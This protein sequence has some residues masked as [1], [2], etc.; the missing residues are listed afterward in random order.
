MANSGFFAVSISRSAQNSH[1]SS[2]QVRIDDK[3]R[4]RHFLSQ[5]LRRDI[6]AASQHECIHF[7]DVHLPLS[8][9]VN[10][11]AGPFREQ[12]DEP[13]FIA[14]ANPRSKIKHGEKYNWTAGPI[15]LVIAQLLEKLAPAPQ[16]NAT[17][18]LSSHARTV[19]GN[20]RA[21]RGAEKSRAD[22]KRT[23]RSKANAGYCWNPRT[24][25][26]VATPER[27]GRIFH[28]TVLDTYYIPRW[29]SP[30][31]TIAKH[32]PVTL[33]SLIIG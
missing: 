1:L 7:V 24:L 11:N 27:V 16:S 14:R 28:R 3:L 18:L 2:R 26:C 15:T 9:V 5:T 12:R 10:H 19:A 33:I 17:G 25:F 31:F 8:C 30:T 32:L 4:L 6:A 20:R 23:T 22:S 21:G 29:C 13:M